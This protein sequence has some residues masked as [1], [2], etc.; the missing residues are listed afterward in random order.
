MQVQSENGSVIISNIAAKH[1]STNAQNPGPSGSAV[2]KKKMM[3]VKKG[4]Q[5]K[6]TI[7]MKK[8]FVVQTTEMSEG[9]QN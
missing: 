8:T 5:I 1:V 3:R 9:F 4:K 2:I 6:L 7:N